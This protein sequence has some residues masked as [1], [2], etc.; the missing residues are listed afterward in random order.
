MSRKLFYLLSVPLLGLLLCTKPVFG[1]T[2][3][4]ASTA[5]EKGLRYYF[6]RGV[7]QNKERAA[8]FFEEAAK[9]HNHKE[10]Q[11]NLG[12]L[13]EKGEGLRTDLQAAVYWYEQAAHQNHANAQYNLGYL[14]LEGF[15]IHK[16]PI[17]ALAW[18]EKAA[19]QGHAHAEYQLGC[20]Y[21]EGKG[22]P[23]NQPLALTWLERAHAHHHKDAAQALH[24]A[25]SMP[26]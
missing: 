8:A 11:Y 23:R 10:A 24:L 25:Q 3:M 15:G 6:G 2:G 13:Y 1:D 12:V 16:D 19:N 14:L 17:Q 20:A 7:S 5:Y 9:L 21:L 26:L 18:L 4:E 22:V